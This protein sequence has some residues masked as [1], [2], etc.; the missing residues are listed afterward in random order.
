MATRAFVLIETSVGRT[1]DVVEALKSV[2]EVAAVDAVTGPYDIIA[3]V[4]AADLNS[5]GDVVT[6]RV[7]VVP[8]IVRT[9]T[10]LAVSLP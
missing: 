8:G 7:H 9:V 6:S 2:N 10:C 3:V 1:K 5:V 4:E